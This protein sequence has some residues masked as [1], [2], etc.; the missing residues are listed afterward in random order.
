MLV[1][2]VIINHLKKDND[3][4]EL[5]F[6]LDSAELVPALLV[7]TGCIQKTRSLISNHID[8]FLDLQVP[9]AIKSPF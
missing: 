4:A 6:W 2:W 1:R 5:F 8:K 9:S 3:S 7:L